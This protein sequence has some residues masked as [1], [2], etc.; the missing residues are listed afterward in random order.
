MNDQL[1]KRDR[2]FLWITC[3]K[4]RCSIGIY[5][6]FEFR[7]LMPPSPSFSSNYIASFFVLLWDIFIQDLFF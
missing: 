4:F 7:H 2:H 1:E 5:M 3:P 6:Q